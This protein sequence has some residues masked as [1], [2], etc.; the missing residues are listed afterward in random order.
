MAHSI[1]HMRTYGTGSLSIRTNRNGQ[2]S[3]Y[4]QWRVDGIKVCRKLGPVRDGKTGLSEKAA[5]TKLREMM[6]TI[7]PTP[8]SGSLTLDRASDL[9][10]AHLARAGRKK[11]TLVAV[12]SGMRVWM[13]PFFKTTPMGSVTFDQVEDLV[14]TMEQAGLSAKSIHNY[15]GTLGALYRYGMN[16]RRGWATVNPTEG[17]ELPAIPQS[18]EI[19][20][21]TL[22]ELD[23]LIRAVPA[24]RYQ[25]LDRVLYRTA[26]MTGLREGELIALR[27]GD[28]DWQASKVR[29]RRNYVLNE[30][31]TPKSRRSTRGV[32]L[33]DELAKTLAGWQP[34]DATDESA[35]FPDPLTGGE[36]SK[37]AIMRRYRRALKAAGLGHHVFHGLRHT[38][39]TTMA[40]AGVPMRTLQEWLG[41]RDIQTTMRYA[42]YAPSAHEAQLVDQ[43]FARSEIEEAVRD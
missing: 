39:G 10:R 32:P 23:A 1:A 34:R 33:A 30:Y 28:V 9:Y 11:S 3:W 36:L 12:E 8:T 27:W 31:D 24:G 4:G 20:F 40:A 35:V 25:D 26:A 37:A 29:V 22:E 17:V 18:D 38:F 16:P 2:Q 7:T 19:R 43:A 13:L 41:H 21:L 14:D 5:E 42:D 15:I 6:G